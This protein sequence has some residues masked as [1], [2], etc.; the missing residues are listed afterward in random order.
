MHLTG[1]R[2]KINGGYRTFGLVGRPVEMERQDS[3]GVWGREVKTQVMRRWTRQVDCI[4]IAIAALDG[5]RAD[6]LQHVVLIIGQPAD[7]NL[8]SERETGTGTNNAL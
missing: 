4:I 1:G 8:Q 2:W 3:K 6:M 5:E 7:H